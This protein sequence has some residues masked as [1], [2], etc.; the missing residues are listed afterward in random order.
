MHVIGDPVLNGAEVL[1][2]KLL[3]L[4][5]GRTE[6]SPACK[7]EIEALHIELFIYQKIFLFRA[8]RGGDLCGY[9]VAKRFQYT[10][11]L[12]GKGPHRSEQ[13]CFFVEGLSVVGIEC[14]RDGKRN[15]PAFVFL[16][17]GR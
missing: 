17:E 9:S 6:Y 7:Q 15:I 4:R 13:R 2:F 14:C 16:Q 10:Q 5:C 8:Y 11:R 12:F 1:V 3:P